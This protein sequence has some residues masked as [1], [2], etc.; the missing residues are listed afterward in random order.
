MIVIFRIFPSL[1]N[2]MENIQAGADVNLANDGGRIALHYAASKG[3][4]KVAEILISHGSKLNRKDKVCVI[5]NVI[6]RPSLYHVCGFNSALLLLF[7]C[8]Y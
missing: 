8:Q 1:D 4:L 7:H 6:L 2:D 5:S 3:W